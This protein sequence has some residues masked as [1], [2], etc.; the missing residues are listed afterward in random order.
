MKLIFICFCSFD[1]TDLSVHEKT[2]FIAS[3][4]YN[5]CFSSLGSVATSACYFSLVF[6]SILPNFSFKI[7]LCY[8]NIAYKHSHTLIINFLR[9]ENIYLEQDRKIGSTKV[10]HPFIPLILYLQGFFSILSFLEHNS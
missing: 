1:L 3:I 10:G 8:S 4:S 5:S 7:Q 6:K 2:A 9:T